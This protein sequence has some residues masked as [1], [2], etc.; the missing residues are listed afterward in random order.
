MKKRIGKINKNIEEL[1]SLEKTPSEL[2]DLFLQEKEAFN[3]STETIKQYRYHCVQFIH[4][5]ENADELPGYK[6]LT[7]DSYKNY[8]VELKK[9]DIKDVSIA[10][11]ARS[12]RA[13]L[14]WLMENNYINPFHVKIPKYQK[15]VAETYTDEELAILLEKPGRN[16]SE[17]EYETWVFINVAIATG[18]RLSSILNIKVQDIHFSE[19]TIVVN[20]TKNRTA[21]S[22]VANDELLAILK[23]YV[24]LFDLYPEDYLFCTGEKGKLANRTMEDFV[25]RYNAK[26]GVQKKKI[27]HAFRHT[28]ARNHYLQN[29]DMYRLKNLMGHTL[30]STTEHY[31]GT[32]GL[33]TSDK[34]EYNPQAQFIKK[35][36]Q[37]RNRRQSIN[38]K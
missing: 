13:W 30:I 8:I 7:L 21:L 20:K 17:V 35:P 5:I 11:I 34:I 26:R 2:L 38:K 31:L 25:K 18:L 22:L 4:S 14:Y 27:I 32:L 23:R 10:C 15:V 3:A 16:C 9:R 24:K 33:N 19:N 28:F 29:H 12:L 6:V 1:N 36:K 37:T